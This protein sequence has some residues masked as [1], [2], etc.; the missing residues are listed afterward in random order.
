MDEVT[1]TAARS[2]SRGPTTS[3]PTSA[4]RAA[5]A[6]VGYAVYLLAWT[7]AGLFFFSL[8]LTRR[9]YGN[10][11]APW[12]KVLLSWM[13]GAYLWAA[14]TPAV[15][16]LG[17]RWPIERGAWLRRT[18]GHL[19]LAA[20]FAVVQLALETAAYAWV[21]VGP[22][23][24]PFATRFP[25][26]LARGGAHFNVVAYWAV[27]GLQAAF[28]HYRAYQERER[29]ALRLELR[30][31]ALQ[32][33]VVR[34]QLSALK[35][36]LQ[37]HFLFN[38]LNAVVVLVRQERASE[39]EGMLERLSDLLRRVLEDMDAQEVPLHRELDYVQL[40]LSIEQAR[41]ADRLRVDIDADP[42]ALD[43]AVPHLG[44]QPIVE[45]AVRHGIG[46]RL[47]AGAIHIGA[48]CAGGHLEITVRD[49]GPGFAPERAAADRGI[50]LSNTRA[51]LAQLHGDAARLT[52]EPGPTGGAIV[53]MRLP[54]RLADGK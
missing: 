28:R 47:A 45:N 30:A 41:F 14:L 11:P 19:F 7:L 20:G 38:T 44:L 23:G 12:T 32:T 1:G 49:D 31:S 46:G 4:A 8:N 17:E 43:A 50:G 18:A 15:L 25:L 34:A 35:M 51:R 33:Q 16:W 42:A 40:Y 26:A 21:G 29:E 24:R 22:P 27:L 54:Y 36:Q 10:D 3:A 9:L 2:H 37:P 6:R 52:I 48:S 5:P 53:T 39:A 13:V